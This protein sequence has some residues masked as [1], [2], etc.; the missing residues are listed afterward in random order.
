M[1]SV[2]EEETMNGRILDLHVCV[3]G[4]P[5]PEYHHDGA[6]W[7]EGRSGS[8]YVL[9]LR[10]RTGKR[11]E[12][13][14]TVDGINVV[15]A[16]EGSAAGTGYVLGPYQTTDIKGFLRDAAHAAAFTFGAGGD[17]Y[18]AKLGR[19]AAHVGVI[20][21]AVFEEKPPRVN[22]T[23]PP[24]VGIHVC[25][26][27]PHPYYPPVYIGPGFGL[28]GTT[29]TQNPAAGEIQCSVGSAQVMDFGGSVK[30]Q[31][32]GTSYGRE[33]DF[34][35][36]TTTFERATEHPAETFTIRYDDAE[37][38]RQRGVPVGAVRPTPA[39]PSA[40]PADQI[41]GCPAPEGWRP[42]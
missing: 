38:L 32:L 15:N 23:L 31:N 5:L 2:D 22:I 11:V 39:A 29:G 26:W 4:R 37:G 40:F 10:N 33:V 18:R 19:D 35:T 41:A 20:G 8:D 24:A 17:A 34:S 6:T 12:A 28:R 9:R 21:A 27:Q 16:E 13:V 1:I 36:V 3:Q 14:V 42:A 7:V 25:S 30:T